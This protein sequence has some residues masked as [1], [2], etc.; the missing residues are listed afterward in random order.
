[1][2]LS[3]S[4]CLL[5]LLLS[6]AALPAWAQGLLERVPLPRG[7][8]ALDMPRDFGGASLAGALVQLSSK[9]GF[10]YLGH[11]RDCGLPEASLR[12]IPGI[13]G[14]AATSRHAFRLEAGAGATLL[15]LFSLELKGEAGRQ[16]EVTLGEATDEMLVPIGVV[17]AARANE[18]ILRERC[19]EV[20][21]LQNVF[22]VNSAL[23][24]QE[25]RIR[26]LNAAGGRVAGSAEEIGA[27]VAGL[28]AQADVSVSTEGEIVLRRPVYIA[29][30][31]A[32]PAELLTG[33]IQL[34]S[35]T[36]NSTPPPVTFGDEVYVAP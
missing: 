24:V 21:A 1:M 19:G 14:L 15:R 2:Q 25:I 11:L 6:V 27:Q 13:A 5:A 23:R 9:R 3:N 34:H 12:P 28:K 29:F 31:D 26:L 33:R 8:L 35:V 36:A 20:L 32:P 10:R 22:W 17:G 16:L 30:R 4:T 18:R 7:Y